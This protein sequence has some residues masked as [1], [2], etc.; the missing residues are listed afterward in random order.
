VVCFKSSSGS[1]AFDWLTPKALHTSVGM[2]QVGGLAGQTPSDA[3][4]TYLEWEP[5]D[6]LPAVS[7]YR[8]YRRPHTPGSP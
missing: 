3:G 2:G 4:V 7:G 6:P 8:I 5:N 1:T